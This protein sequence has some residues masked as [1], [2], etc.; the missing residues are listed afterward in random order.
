[1]KY[2]TEKFVDFCDTLIVKDKEEKNLKTISSEEDFVLLRMM[3]IFSRSI[4]NQSFLAFYKI[5]DGITKI[6][7]Y[8]N[9]KLQQ[10]FSPL[11]EVFFLELKLKSKCSF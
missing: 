9:F 1:L 3:E 5:F 7:N 10:E 11:L 2:F 4:H 8:L 6:I